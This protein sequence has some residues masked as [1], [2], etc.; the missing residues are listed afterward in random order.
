VFSKRSLCI[1]YSILVLLPMGACRADTFFEA[2]ARGN[3][4]MVKSMLKGSPALVKTVDKD[5]ATALHYAAATGKRTAAE[6]LLANGADVNA[7]KKDG[8]TPLHVAAALGQKDIAEFL[9]YKKASV[10]AT[11]N[12]G[13]TPLMLA[14]ERRHPIVAKLLVA[15][16]AKDASA[17]P[18]TRQNTAT[19][20]LA[21]AQPKTPDRKLVEA[22]MD[23]ATA[24]LLIWTAACKGDTDKV[25][26]L[27]IS[28]AGPNLVN[29]ETKGDRMTPLQ[30]AA[31]Y[32][33]MDTVRL[34]ILQGAEVNHKDSAGSTPL[35]MAAFHGHTKIANVLLSRGADINARD[36]A[37]ETPI[38]RAAN[39]GHTATVTLLVAKGASVD[40]KNN[41]GLT[42]LHEAAI[43]GHTP[44]VKLLMQ[45]G[46]DKDAKDNSGRTA[47]QY[48]Q[49]RKH[50]AT[51]EALSTLV[52][53]PAEKPV[54][55]KPVVTI[56]KKPAPQVKPPAA[57]QKKPAARKK[58][59]SAKT[60]VTPL[61]AITPAD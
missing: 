36:R 54:P 6:F 43:N 3:M 16:G 38:H 60:A 53:A 24:G 49:D 28:A 37:G 41:A 45:K 42:P 26:S 25:K 27:L 14:K 7:R 52:L 17:A 58:S 2:A 46:A 9:I 44:M 1:L 51:A 13:R 61:P 33:H 10:N 59:A 32:G 19:K 23:A 47:L 29:Y 40:A 34:L 18:K 22:P 21:P 15:A 35:H 56:Q 57:T 55:E 11:D 39:G 4:G 31:A 48:A 5:G 30:G 50:A 20:A 12:K 8:V